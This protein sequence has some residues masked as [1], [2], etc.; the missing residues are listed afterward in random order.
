M[1]PPAGRHQRGQPLLVGLVCGQ[2]R[3]DPG[4]AGGQPGAGPQR[5]AA[6]A[7]RADQQHDPGAVHAARQQLGDGDRER[8]RRPAASAGPP[9]A[10]P[11]PAPRRV[12]TS[13]TA[14]AAISAAGPLGDHDGRRD[15]GVVREGD[16]QRG[17]AELARPARRRCPRRAGAG[18]HRRR[19]GPRRRSSAGRPGRPATWP[20]PPWPRSSAASEL[21]GRCRSASVN[22][23]CISAGVR[24][25]VCSNRATSTTSMPT[26]TITGRSRPTQR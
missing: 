2:H 19:A 25:R 7:A 1:H 10:R 8:A 3:V 12:R 5:V 24:R 22:S 14:Y 15:P 13:S 11:S 26:P 6:V 17:D 4:P 23:R 18:G 20:A 9:A 21:I 16:V